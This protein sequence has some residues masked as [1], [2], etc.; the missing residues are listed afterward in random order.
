MNARA[1]DLE[2]EVVV[3]SRA[4]TNRVHRYAS[5]DPLEPGAVLRLD[6][7]FWLIERVEPAGKLPRA[8]ATPARYRIRLRHPDG[9]EE[10]GAYRRFRS[11]AP[12]LGHGF[13]TIDDGQPV[14]WEVTDERL[15][16]DEQGEPYLDLLAERDFLEVEELPDH[17]L[18][19][20]LAGR[21]QALPEEASA[22]LSDAERRGSSVELV[23]LEP[24]EL[25]DWEEAARYIDALTLDEIEDD[26]LELSGVDPDRDPR[27][28]WLT[29]VKERLRADLSS[30]R[31][32]IDGEQ[33]EVEEWEFLDGRIFAATGDFVDESDPDSAYGWLCR[34]VDASALGAAGFQRV[35][36]TELELLE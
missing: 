36:K 5:D 23:A 17:E 21:E 25:P 10:P 12:R 22:M 15:A 3:H 4:G 6:G 29:T 14:G 11:G 1:G 35:R 19:H 20:T 18:E 28:T 24:G 26:L 33:D 13:T 2:Y 8:F 31:A 27:E 16:F 30:L 7:R 32:D 34:L 9:R